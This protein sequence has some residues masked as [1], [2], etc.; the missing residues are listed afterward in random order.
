MDAL[1]AMTLQALVVITL[2]KGRKGLT[3]NL[4]LLIY[5]SAA[6]GLSHASPVVRASCGLFRRGAQALQ[7]QR[8][9]P[10]ALWHAGS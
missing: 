2:E 1:S 3:A 8:A 9:G 7:P 10:V 4:P 5:Y 6:S